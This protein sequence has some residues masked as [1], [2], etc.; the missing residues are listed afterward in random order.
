MTMKSMNKLRVLNL[1]GSVISLIYSL[2][3]GAWPTV[4]LNLCLA[5]INLF[6]LIRERI[7]RKT[8]A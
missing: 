7:T 8:A 3:I 5:L 2:T 6:H 4:V 1:S